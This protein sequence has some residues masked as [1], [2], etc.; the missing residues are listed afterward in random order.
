M[1]GLNQMKKAKILFTLITSA[2][3]MGCSTNSFNSDNLN[4]DNNIQKKTWQ[5]IVEPVALSNSIFED[6]SIKDQ[7]QLIK[8]DSEFN[9]YLG[10]LK[11]DDSYLSQSNLIKTY[12]ELDDDF[13]S[14][15]YLVIVSPIIIPMGSQVN[16]T[17]LKE[18][19]V[20]GDKMVVSYYQETKESHYPAYSL[21]LDLFAINSNMN[22]SSIALEIYSPSNNNEPM[23]T[24]VTNL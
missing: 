16:A 14:Y 17:Y 22:I 3:V 19:K 5:G 8:S 1:L 20:N 11:D 10:Y 9:H 24:E 7:S 23:Y 18:A 12:Q 4:K 15:C 13:F 21:A 2:L 6:L